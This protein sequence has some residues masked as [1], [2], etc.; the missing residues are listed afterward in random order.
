MTAAP[1]RPEPPAR[2]PLPLHAHETLETE[3]VTR[4]MGGRL[5]LRVASSV[6]DGHRAERD[7][8]RLASRI[9]VWAAR[10]TRFDPASDLCTLNAVPE[11]S[12]VALRPTISAVLAHARSMTPRTEGAVDVTLLEERMAAEAFEAARPSC[13]TSWQLEQAGRLGLLT[14]DGS[15]RFDLDGV[16]K[17]WI[18][19]RAVRLLDDYPS[20]LVDAD[21]DLAMRA[22]RSA[23]WLVSVGHPLDDTAG[24]ARLR[25][26]LGWPCERLGVATS[27]TSVHRWYGP[28]GP[29]H[30]LI[31]PLTRRPAVT[32]VVQATV[33]AES[34][35]AAEC[36][37]KAA[38]IRGSRAGL[39]LLERAGA[40]AALL[41]LDDGRLVT[42]PGTSGWLV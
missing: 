10:L 21:G 7:L 14:R 31:D 5:T 37:A 8:R 9:E 4:S 40:W 32:D 35:G 38:V 12:A 24:V 16:A 33:V 17:G 20:A 26:P 25:T 23:G 28:S 39:G 13:R 18:A 11:A 42:A 15:A 22:P 41:W 34:A 19:D 3:L 27:G 1:W 2:M 6:E 36:L 30:H 29:S